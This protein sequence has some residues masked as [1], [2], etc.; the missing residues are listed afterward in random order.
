MDYCKEERPV[1]EG[2]ITTAEAGELTGY[3]IEYLRRLARKGK[4]KA[5]KVGRSWLFD[6]EDLEEHQQTARRGRPAIGE[7]AGDD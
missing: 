1:V 4:V 3:S 5:H 6:K 7:A 2:W